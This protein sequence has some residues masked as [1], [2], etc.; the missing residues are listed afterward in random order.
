MSNFSCVGCGPYWRLFVQSLS[1][2][3]AVLQK[4]NE[5]N[6][7]QNLMNQQHALNRLEVK[8]GDL[9]GRIRELVRT[10]K[11]KE[12]EALVR[13]KYKVLA[14]VRKTM[15]VIDFTEY[16]LSQIT[17]TSMMKD[18]ISTLND[19]Q[20]LFDSIDV[21]RLY[22]KFDT[23]SSKHSR[24]RTQLEEGQSMMDDRMGDLATVSLD[25]PELNAE[26]AAM[27]AEMDGDA[28]P[29]TPVGA[30]HVVV[31]PP[32]GANVASAYASAGLV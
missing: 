25:D 18:T 21:P 2:P 5:A 26:L 13:D 24:F 11:R 1:K 6:L 4:E 32:R 17:Q 31:E 12:A 7:R 8:V 29:A 3:K 30:V 27:M 23:L 16:M 14:L 20:N 22:K 19:A 9:D 10:K 28:M 15:G